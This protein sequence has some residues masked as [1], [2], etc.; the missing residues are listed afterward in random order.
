MK[1]IRCTHEKSQTGS[2][3]LEG[4]FAILIF[5]MGILGLVGLQAA[6]VRQSSDAKYRVEA[7]L[8]ADELL[9]KMWSTDRLPAT[10][11]TKFQENSDDFT[12]WS[13]KVK[14][15]LPGITASA[16]QPKVVVD[17]SGMVTITISWQPPGD[18]DSHSYQTVAQIM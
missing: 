18:S 10:L 8:L 16:N 1:T 14:S 17:A 13:G 7:S 4:L 5:S 12:D 3:L 9:G 2:M 11:Q 6:A 15:T